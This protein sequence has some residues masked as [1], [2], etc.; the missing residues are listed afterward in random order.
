MHASL[1]IVWLLVVLVLAGGCGAIVI[2]R[3][4]WLAPGDD[5]GDWEKSLVDYRNLRD[6]GVLSEE[7]YRNIRTLVEPRTRFGAPAS[8]G[9]HS[10]A[11]DAAGLEHGRD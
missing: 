9:R 4:R 3:R 5:R 8:D 1:A 2:I 10:P 11:A 7:E 6:E